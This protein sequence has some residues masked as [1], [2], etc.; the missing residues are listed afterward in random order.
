MSDLLLIVHEFLCLALVYTVFC[1]SVDMNLSALLD[2]RLAF[3]FLGV[4]ACLGIPAPL[5]WGWLPD[6]FSVALLFGIVLVQVITA[7]HWT[8]GLPEV[9]CKH[10]GRQR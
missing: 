3:F 9:F 5:A 10:P 7:R 1:R 2:V 8:H 4:V 6:A